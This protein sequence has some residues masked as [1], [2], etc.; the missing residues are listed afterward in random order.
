MADPLPDSAQE[1]I[2]TEIFRGQKIEAIKLYRAATGTDLKTAKDAVES[3]ESD[4]RA[5]QPD[6][7]TAAPSGGGCLG[8]LLIA[9]VALA[10]RWILK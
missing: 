10:A 9:P 8:M 6:R 5:R 1:Q 7:F 3:M 2:H 4:L